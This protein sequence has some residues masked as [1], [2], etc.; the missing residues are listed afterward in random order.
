M[1]STSTTMN[2]PLPL[3]YSEGRCGDDSTSFTVADASDT[4]ILLSADKTGGCDINTSKTIHV[5]KATDVPWVFMDS[6][7]N[8]VHQVNQTSTRTNRSPDRRSRLCPVQMCIPDPCWISSIQF[9]LH[10]MLQACAISGVDY[11]LG[12]ITTISQM[13]FIQEITSS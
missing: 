1:Y 10:L 13:Q 4:L 6:T 9:H 7:N 11:S 3:Q 12:L 5:R 2:E 8:V